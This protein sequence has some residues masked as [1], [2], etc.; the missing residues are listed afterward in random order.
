[1]LGTGLLTTGRL[2][3]SAK[4][5]GK[6]KISSSGRCYRSSLMGEVHDD[7]TQ[8]QK[9]ADGGEEM[10]PFGFQQEHI[11]RKPLATGM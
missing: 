11:L 5:P 7:G 2:E 10:E 3:P 4:S 1:M 8:L 9:E 6:L